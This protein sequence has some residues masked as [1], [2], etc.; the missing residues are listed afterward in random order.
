[1]NKFQDA[2]KIF[3]SEVNLNN[4]MTNNEGMKEIIES[5]EI[6]K[7][8]E[9]EKEKDKN[10][11]NENSQ[12]KEKENISDNPIV[13]NLYRELNSI[14]KVL[15]KKVIEFQTLGRDCRGCG[16]GGVGTYYILRRNNFF[17][18]WFL[19]SFFRCTERLFHFLNKEKH[20]SIFM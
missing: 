13:S 4:F 17:N 5:V 18:F 6:E 1:M 14:S 20:Y 9:K 8:K 11:N 7:E 15:I 16:K 3:N 2:A 12:E 19:F 10:L